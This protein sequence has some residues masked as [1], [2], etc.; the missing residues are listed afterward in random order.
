VNQEQHIISVEDVCDFGL[1]REG[2]TSLHNSN[3][4]GLQHRL[5]LVTAAF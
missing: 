2:V 5:Y 4:Y 1:V 3:E